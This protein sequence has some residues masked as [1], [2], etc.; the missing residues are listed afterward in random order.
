MNIEMNIMPAADSRFL[1]YGHVEV[2]EI[3][4]RFEYRK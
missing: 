1:M 2:F 3:H 4:Y